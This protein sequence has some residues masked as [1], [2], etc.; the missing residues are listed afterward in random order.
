MA[1]AILSRFRIDRDDDVEGDDDKV[2]VASL[3]EGLSA[4]GLAIL[5][6]LRMTLMMMLMVM[7]ISC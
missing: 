1:L 2:D 5:S 7:M 6:R 3:G 4:V